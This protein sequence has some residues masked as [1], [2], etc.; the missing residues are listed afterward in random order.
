MSPA[1]PATGALG[2]NDR[3]DVLIPD[4]GTGLTPPDTAGQGTGT[5]AITRSWS[6]SVVRATTSRSQVPENGI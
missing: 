3:G 2:I 1:S 6:M 5:S 4:L